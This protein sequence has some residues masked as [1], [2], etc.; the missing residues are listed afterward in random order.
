MPICMAK[1][2][3]AVNAPDLS[4]EAREEAV[5]PLASLLRQVWVNHLGA[6]ASMNDLSCPDTEPM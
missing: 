6:M 3:I 1:F 4:P 5:K 2:V